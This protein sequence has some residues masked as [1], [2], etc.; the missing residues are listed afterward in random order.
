MYDIKM[1]GHQ[2]APSWFWVSLA[3]LL[4]GTIL[5]YIVLQGGRKDQVNMEK[6]TTYWQSNNSKLIYNT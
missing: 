6:G 5:A 2:K 3:L 4:I 1:G